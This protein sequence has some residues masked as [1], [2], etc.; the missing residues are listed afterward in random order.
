ME[1][2]EGVHILTVIKYQESGIFV[3]LTQEACC[4]WKLQGSIPGD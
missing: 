4:S 1:K 2:E 3:K